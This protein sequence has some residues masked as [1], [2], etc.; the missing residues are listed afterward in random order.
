MNQTVCSDCIQSLN[1]EMQIMREWN[2]YYS[3]ITS[4]IIKSDKHENSLW[5][6]SRW[7]WLSIWLSQS[8]R[9]IS[10]TSSPWI[11]PYSRTQAQSFSLYKRLESEK[12]RKKFQNIK[13]SNKK[14]MSTEVA[15]NNNRLEGESK[16]KYEKLKKQLETPIETR[17]NVNFCLLVY[18]LPG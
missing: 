14:N 5:A 6:S 18:W 2:Y 4:K 3:K 15:S 10:V 8:W 9:P 7:S 11:G 16:I 13:F 12:N 1:G 17:I